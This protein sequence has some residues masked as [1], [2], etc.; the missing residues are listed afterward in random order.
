MRVSNQNVPGHYLLTLSSDDLVSSGND[1]IVLMID[2]LVLVNIG[3]V[4]CFVFAMKLWEKEK[5][6]SFGQ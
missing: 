4:Y 1:A 6:E 3:V 2:V 5:Q